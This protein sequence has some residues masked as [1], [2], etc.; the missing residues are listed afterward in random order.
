MT[1]VYLIVVELSEGQQIQVG[2]RGRL[3]LA[4]G[5]Y[6][7]VGSALGSLEKRL[8]R[9]LSTQKKLHWHIDYL[10]DKGGVRAVIFA[11]TKRKEECFI[12]RALS[13]RLSSIPGFGSSDCNCHSHL[14]F[15][16]D[17]EVLKEHAL[18][19]F[20]SQNLAPVS[21]DLTCCPREW[22]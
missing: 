2:R 14:V 16:E 1:G 15:S 19:A 13:E 6:G 5:F 8:G 10:L 12:A 17:F 11:E 22:A 3:N 7:Y 4:K 18:H 20:K 9:H 21:T